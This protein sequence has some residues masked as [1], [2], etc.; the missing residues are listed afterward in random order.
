M[1]PH[2]T[3]A[4]HS[5]KKQPDPLF[6]PI[7]IIGSGIAGLITAHVLLQDG[8]KSVEVLTRDKSVG[9]VWSEERVYPGLRINRSV[10]SSHLFHPQTSNIEFY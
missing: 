10:S 4:A 2:D 9:G 1:T 6:E 8:F 7:G 5:P 3:M